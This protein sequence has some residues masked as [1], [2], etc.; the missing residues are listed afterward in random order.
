MNWRKNDIEK[1]G[2]ILN[3]EERKNLK[4]WEWGQAKQQKRENQNWIKAEK[5]TFRNI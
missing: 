2:R 4:A 3:P 5:K 1:W